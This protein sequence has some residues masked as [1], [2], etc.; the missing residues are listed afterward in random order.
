[1][2]KDVKKAFNN[3]GGL[4]TEFTHKNKL[5]I[6]LNKKNEVYNEIN[7]SSKKSLVKNEVTDT[8][9]KELNDDKNKE[10]LNSLVKIQKSPKKII[11]KGINFTN[12]EGENPLK[13]KQKPTHS[14]IK[15]KNNN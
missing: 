13:I 7:D 15:L 11:F 5:F 1:M 14:K 10:Q 4:C 6:D 2:L 3:K 12:I 9:N 8:T